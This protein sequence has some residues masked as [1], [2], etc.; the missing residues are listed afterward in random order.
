ME[1]SISA[2]STLLESNDTDEKI[3][4]ITVLWFD[5]TIGVD[6]DSTILMTKLKKLACNCVF[7]TDQEACINYI[8]S[9]GKKEKLFFILSGSCAVAGVLSLVHPLRQIDSIY[10]YCFEREK[11]IHIL[12]EYSK[13]VDIYIDEDDLLDSLEDEA[14]LV[15][16]QAETFQF[17]IQNQKSTR[18][19]EV[20]CGSFLWFKLFSDLIMNMPQDDQQAKDEMAEKCKEYY[21]DNEKKLKSIDE[22]NREYIPEDALRWYTRPTFVFKLINR[23][24]RTEDFEELRTFRFFIVHLSMSIAREHELVKEWIDEITLYRGAR[25]LNE[26][27]GRLKESVGKI[28]STNGFLSTTQS[29]AVA[30]TFAGKS[31]ATKQSVI[32]EIY[33]NVN[34]LNDSVKFGDI[35]KFSVCPDEQEFLFELGATFLIESIEEKANHYLIKLKTTDDGLKIAQEHIENNRKLCELAGGETDWTFGSFLLEIEQYSQ[36]KTYFQTLLKNNVTDNLAFIYYG[37]GLAENGLG[38]NLEALK[39]YEKVYHLFLNASPPKVGAFAHLQNTIGDL[40]PYERNFE[41]ALNCYQEALSLIEKFRD[42]DY[43]LT[44][45]THMN[46]GSIY[47]ETGELQLALAHYMKSFSIKD[48]CL[49][50]VH[51]ERAASLKSIGVIL[52]EMELFDEALNYYN[53]ALEMK[54]KSLPNVHR[55]ISS[56]LTDI[57][58]IYLKQDKVDLALEYYERALKMDESVYANNNG[59]PDIAVVLNNIGAVYY[60]KQNY[61]QALK[62]MKQGLEMR[63]RHLSIDHPDIGTSFF[64]IGHVLLDQ[65]E[66]DDA[67]SYC[68]KAFNIRIKL[69][70]VEHPNVIKCLQMITLI[71]N[72]KGSY[73]G[74]LDKW[75]IQ[76]VKIDGEFVLNI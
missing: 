72:E 53:K 43:R 48:K 18:D 8:K 30:I 22:F 20:E 69:Y 28:I 38:R 45:F 65:K 52:E 16:Q 61:V 2:H 12:D 3:D 36:A 31:T 21:R 41:Y 67:L 34:Q 73:D 32:F 19:L 49:P 39:Y 62:Y 33:C 58:N 24:L 57:G 13:I 56:Q 47:Q 76:V 17:Y 37:L 10:I 9:I 64:N 40:Y 7:I 46:I 71:Y 11:Y 23:A 27:F 35:T 63:E 25:M 14:Q 44:A 59:H 29:E 55:Q 60:T 51:R 54:E 1:N 5:E 42:N 4:G 70:P 75:G 15:Q 74:A 66:Y 26:E 50:E 68:L 6:K